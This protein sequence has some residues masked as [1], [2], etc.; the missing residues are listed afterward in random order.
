MDV[1]EDVLFKCMNLK[2]LVGY[3]NNDLEKHF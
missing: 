1:I 2:L 3:P